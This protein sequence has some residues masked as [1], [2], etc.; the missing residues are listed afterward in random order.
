MRPGFPGALTGMIL[1]HEIGHAQGLN[2][3][4]SPLS[5]MYSG[6]SGSLAA[7]LSIAEAN[8]VYLKNIMASR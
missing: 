3:A 1:P 5:L 8:L 6:L 4:P 2:H 7:D